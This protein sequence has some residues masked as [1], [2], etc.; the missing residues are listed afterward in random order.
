MDIEDV[1]IVCALVIRTRKSKQKK[2]H[3]VHPIYSDILLKG[4]FHTLHEKLKEYPK[5]FFG[6]YRMNVKSFNMLLELLKSRSTCQNT[7]MRLAVPPEE[8]LAVTDERK[9]LANVNV[10]FIRPTKL[11]YKTPCKC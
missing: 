2:Q 9:H 3:W 10:N 7:N 8:R 6:Y 4:Q 11:G 1:E 5:K